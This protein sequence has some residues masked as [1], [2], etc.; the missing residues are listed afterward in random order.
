MAQPDCSWGAWPNAV[1]RRKVPAG[2]LPASSFLMG[3]RGCG[4]TGTAPAPQPKPLFPTTTVTG[5]PMGFHFLCTSARSNRCNL[6]ST[7]LQSEVVT[8]NSCVDEF[9]G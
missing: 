5:S 9:N 2:A 7:A 6:P 4:S 8:T 1:L 3:A